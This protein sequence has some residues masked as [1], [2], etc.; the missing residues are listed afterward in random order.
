MT[1]SNRASP[2]A[3][4]FSIQNLV[5]SVSDPQCWQRSD[6][7]L[8][9]FPATRECRAHSTMSSYTLATAHWARPRLHSWDGTTLARWPMTAR[10]CGFRS[11]VRLRC[12]IRTCGMIRARVGC[13]C[14]ITRLDRDDLRSRWHS[15][16][17]CGIWYVMRKRRKLV[18]RKL[19]LLLDWF[20]WNL[21][22]YVWMYE[23]VCLWRAAWREDCG[24]VG[25][26]V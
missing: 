16:C 12:S 22:A 25:V 2:H 11:P 8:L 19:Q 21:L 1:L 3:S 10:S 6:V 7:L 4:A 14:H 26:E 17:T 18:F 23:Y 15:I 13:A 20:S 9:S 5:Q 24:S